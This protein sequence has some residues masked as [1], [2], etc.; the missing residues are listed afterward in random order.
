MVDQQ[1]W[2][3]A[4]REITLIGHGYGHGH[5]M[6]QYG[7]QGAALQGLT[8]EEILAFYYPGTKLEQTTGKIRVLISADTSPDLIVQPADGL[9][10]RDLGDGSTHALPAVDGATRWRVKPGSDG[11]DRVAYFNGS[12]HVVRLDGRATLAGSGEFFASEPITLVLPSGSRTY[13]GFLR[14]AV[15]SDGGR[16]TVNVVSMDDYARGVVPYEMPP[17]WEPEAVQS[18]AVAARSYG[19]WSRSAHAS[20]YY[21]I[22]D[23]TMCQVY[24]GV[25]GEDPRSNDA[26]S[27]TAGQILT[28]KGKPAFTQFSSSN[29]GWMSAGSAPYLVSKEDPYD[30]WE[31]NPVHDW[32]ITVDA[33][34]LENTYPSIG[35]LQRIVVTE[36][37]GGGEWRGRVWK[38]KLVG[39]DASVEIYGESMRYLL[40]LRSTWFSVAPTQILMRWERIGGVD[41]VL[42]QVEAPE[43]EVSGG[44]AQR[45]TGGRIYYSSATGARELYGIVL[46]KYRKLGAAGSQ[47]GLPVTPTRKVLDGYAARFVNGSLY[48]REGKGVVLLLAD[49]SDR[50]A[51]YGGPNTDLGWPISAMKE[52]ETGLRVDFQHGFI[53]YFT[54]TDSTRVVVKD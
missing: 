50:Y 12:W 42:G 52:T 28:Y 49:I 10:V 1:Y 14:L 30:G 26:S 17:S 40:G 35:R 15:N 47:L 5:G 25:D 34:K 39:T 22:C 44:Y 27:A 31:G 46:T 45:F 38:L 24:N 4:S 8:N 53:E 54:A 33:A 48:G 13:R 18:Q 23:T 32:K 11:V 16:D 51:E 20:Q 36:R 2:I 37:D 41:S 6:S 7:A 9:A 19:A 3:A 29:G 21:Q 43:A